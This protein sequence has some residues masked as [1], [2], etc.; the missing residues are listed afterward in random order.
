MRIDVI[1]DTSSS[2]A[3]RKLSSRSVSVRSPSNDSQLVGALQPSEAQSYEK[4]EDFVGL[5][6]S[7]FSRADK[8]PAYLL[9]CFRNELELLQSV[10]RLENSEEGNG[11][12]LLKSPIEE[13]KQQDFEEEEATET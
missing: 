11:R 9:N 10:D 6:N 3:S 13:L 7:N 1:E 4:Y 5:I 8:I 2:E 12:E